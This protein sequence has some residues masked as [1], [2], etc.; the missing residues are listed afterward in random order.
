MLGA[1][2]RGSSGDSAATPDTQSGA[3]S[4]DRPN[5]VLVLTAGQRASDLDVMSEVTELRERGTTFT[6]AYATSTDRTAAT[7]SLLS[8]QTVHG[9]AITSTGLADPAVVDALF[10]LDT[11][12]AWATAAGGHSAFVG[13]LADGAIPEPRN[14]TGFGWDDWF[15][16][17]DG[18][19]GR[20]FSYTTNGNGQLTTR[21]DESRVYNADWV[22]STAV[23]IIGFQPDIPGPFLLVVSYRQPLGPTTAAGV[24]A[25]PDPAPR[26][27]VSADA[28]RRIQFGPEF[29]EADVSDKPPWIA[30]L[31][32]TTADQREGDASWRAAERAALQSV[33]DGIGKIVNAL[34]DTD[35]LDNT[36]VMVASGPATL[37]GEHRVNGVAP[38]PYTAAL[39]APVVVAGP[40]FPKGR[41]VD[42]AVSG[43]DLGLTLFDLWNL[44]GVS[45]LDGVSLRRA[46]VD[47]DFTRSRPLLFEAP[48]TGASPGYRAV[49]QDGWILVAYD[50]AAATRELYD[51][52]DDP[53][54][55]RNL[56]GAGESGLSAAAAA[57]RVQLEFTLGV[58]AA[59]DGS[60]CV[61]VPAAQA[62]AADG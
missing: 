10:N 60:S 32:P 22:T 5:I 26:H 31:P 18:S 21:D 13:T 19:D 54:Q 48:A 62:G 52:D 39:N 49:L 20:S 14:R 4:V 11:L 29:G 59:C 15:A 61:P 57:R 27:V 1:C 7:A 41:A 55:E 2:S 38:G 47:D 8:G 51:L 30:S 53:N 17:A 45:G 58:L 16:F 35:V 25:A 42:N 24:T 23:D 40:G 46:L 34:D 12:G 33:D 56:L 50:D 9:H 43:V 6:H 44:G 28:A 37:R 3:T 36:V